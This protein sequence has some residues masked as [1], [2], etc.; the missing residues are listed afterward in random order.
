MML[1]MLSFFKWGAILGL[2]LL[3][4]DVVWDLKTSRDHSK[5]KDALSHELNTLKAKLFDLQEST[6]VADRTGKTNP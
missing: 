2:A 3:I 4:T 1:K 5:E 6:K